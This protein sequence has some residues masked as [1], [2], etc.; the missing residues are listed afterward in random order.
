M[1]PNSLLTHQS[2]SKGRVPV[3]AR[4]RARFDSL[5]TASL[6]EGQQR[7]W[8]MNDALVILCEVWGAMSQEE[9]LGAWSIFD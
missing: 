1:H 6:Q 2:P 5:V 4:A 8:G 3:K 7:E 9:I